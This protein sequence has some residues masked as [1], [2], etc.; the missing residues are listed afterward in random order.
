MEHGGRG[1][2]SIGVPSG[3]GM[4]PDPRALLC[5]KSAL[6]DAAGSAGP[7]DRGGGWVGQWVPFA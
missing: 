7:G 1:G 3:G 2:V 5:G 6:S 4:A